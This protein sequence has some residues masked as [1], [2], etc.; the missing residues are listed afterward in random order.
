MK[1][2]N[3]KNSTGI[4]A[5][6]TGLLFALV[7]VGLEILTE[8]PQATNSISVWHTPLIWLL[9]SIFFYC[10]F[11]AVGI[12][13]RGRVKEQAIT[14]SLS[15]ALALLLALFWVYPMIST[16]MGCFGGSGC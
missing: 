16:L 5:G 12:V 8:N 14:F 1:I 13:R 4:R 9:A 2:I 15:V 7:Y 11:Y 6:I 10:V 3:A